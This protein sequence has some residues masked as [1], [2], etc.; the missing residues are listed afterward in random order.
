MDSYKQ[1]QNKAVVSL[2]I[3]IIIINISE[4]T[5]VTGKNLITGQLYRLTVAKYLITVSKIL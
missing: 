2:G 4:T 3:I 1:H 5:V